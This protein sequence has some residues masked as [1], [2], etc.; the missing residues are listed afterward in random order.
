MHKLIFLALP[1]F[2]LFGTASLNAQDASKKENQHKEHHAAKD[3]TVKKDDCC[4]TDKKG[5]CCSEDKKTTKDGHGK[6]D[7][8]SVKTVWNV[9]CPV[10][11]EKIEEGA[12]TLEIEGKTVAVCCPGCLS[13]LEKDPAKYLKNL[14]EDGQ[15]WLKK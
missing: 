3:T 11:G 12:K 1:L 4:S 14:S 13:K 2:I 8:A 6:E 10:T 5:D 9:Y 15:T 7:K